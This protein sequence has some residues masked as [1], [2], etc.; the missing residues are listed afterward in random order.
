VEAGFVA[1]RVFA[2]EELQRLREFPEISREE[3]FR[4]FTLSPAD[5]AFVAPQGRGASVRLG[6]AVILCSL[7]W[8][9]FVPDTVTTA[10][11]VVVARLAEQL[12]VNVAQI[13]SYGRRAQTRSEHVRLV[14][15][16]LGWRPAGAIELKELDEFLLARAMEYDSPTLLFR[17]ACE[18]LISARVIRPGP[19]TLVE[20]VAHTRAQAQAE[21]YDRLAHEFTPQRCQELD[22]LLVVDPSLGM[23]RLTWLST[24]PVEASAAAVKA[25]VDKLGF[26]RGLGADTL[27]MSVLPA[28]R[29][30][31]LATMGRRLTGQ[32]LERR[33]PQRRY[34]ILLTLLAQSATD[35]LD[36][37]VQLFDQAISAKF[38]TA[39]K[40]MRDELA[41]RGKTGEDRQALLDDLLSIITDLQI[42][43]EE[44][45]GLIRGEKIGWERLRAAVAQAKPRLPRDHGH[46]A[47]L[48][49]SYSYLRQFTPVVLSSV[50]FASGTAATEL[51]IAVNMLRE[52]NATG[53]RKVFDDAPTG[54]VP[55]K[56][57]GYLDEARKSG[58]VTAYRHYWE[59]CVLLGLRDGLRS[60]DVYVPG[61]RRYADPA[62]YLLTPEQWA[63]QRAEFCR[64]VG[65]SADPAQALASVTDELY[66]AVGELETMLAAETARS[67]STKTAI[68]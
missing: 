61:S 13:G 64:L 31:F 9:G 30:R 66:E 45:G 35:V 22:A 65:K 38:S 6:L 57:R 34:P 28:E 41:E 50:R 46:L 8:L 17:L 63:P 53:A 18:Y 16:Y 12:N 49:A 52:L 1:T 4:Y 25:E 59:L 14:A 55:T 51:L 60:G 54:F 3:L 29:R 26:L 58:S 10:P 43:D 47:A 37:V 7:P 42:P 33:D 56:W 21:T 2:D 23:S 62:A 48:D 19:V 15:Q 39:E 24:G 40:R 68:W 27:D 5:L 11:P 20:R 67:V 36:E 44:I 32:A